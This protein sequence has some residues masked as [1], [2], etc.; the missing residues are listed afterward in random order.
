MS[1][2]LQDRR[3]N[4]IELVHHY[5]GGDGAAA[6]ESFLQQF[7]KTHGSL[8]LNATHYDNMRLQVKGRILDEDPPDLWTGWPGEV[9]TYADVGV[10]AD[11]SNVWESAGLERNFQSAAVDVSKI[12]GAFR[13]VPLAV[14]RYND[15]YLHTDAVEAA[16]IDPQRATDPADLIEMLSQ[17]DAEGEGPGF[18]LPMADPFTVLQ[19]WE[20][21]L[22]GFE[23]IATFEAITNGKAGSHR[24]AISQALEHVVAFADLADD[25]SLYH[26]MTDA[27]QQFI[28]GVA[29]VYAQGDWA[30]GVF[31]DTD[32]FSFGSDWE[33]IPFPGT[34]EQFGV[35]MDAVIP[36]IDADPD[37]LET[38]LAYAGSPEAQETFNQN[39]GSL[40][41]RVDV[42]MDGFSDFSKSQK[43]QLDNAREQPLSITHGLSV[44][45]MTLVDLKSVI[46]EFLEDWDVETTTD[47]MIAVLDG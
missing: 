6:L 47:E 22:L 34:E 44:T 14:H 21:T 25:D 23:D 43:R 2:T 35:V 24:R 16:G 38:F 41:A 29:P 1:S 10:V 32:D 19:L 12:N 3:A 17:V 36:H 13:T 15:L 11:I 4:E 28:D 20:V 42:S 40:P 30:A 9:K 33:R 39:K 26:A 37:A 5:V 46:A 18:L 45:P 31:S 27:N 8:T 7:R